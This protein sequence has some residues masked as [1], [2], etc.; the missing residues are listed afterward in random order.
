[1]QESY[2]QQYFQPLQAPCKALKPQLAQVSGIAQLS[3][4]LG[5]EALRDVEVWIFI[6]LNKGSG[7]KGGRGPSCP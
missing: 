7:G 4:L 5:S 1:M 6:T 3:E 2:Q